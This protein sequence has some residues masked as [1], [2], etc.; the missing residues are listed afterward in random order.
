MKGSCLAGIVGTAFLLPQFIPAQQTIKVHTSLVQVDALVLHKKTG[1]TID[2]L[3]PE[4]F[5]LYEDGVLQKVTNFSKDKLP[6]SIVLALDLTQTVQPV[7]KP[8]ASGAEAALRHLKA[9]DEIAVIAYCSYAFLVDEFTTARART[10]AALKRASEASHCVIDGVGLGGPAWVNEAVYQAARYVKTESRQGTRRIVVVLNDGLRGNVPVNNRYH[11]PHTEK[12]AFAELFESGV[13]VS[14]LVLRSSLSRVGEAVQNTSPM[15][16]QLSRIYHPGSI[17]NYARRT[18]GEEIQGSRIDADVKLTAMFDRLRLFYT[19]GYISSN[20]RLD[21]KFR[22]IKLKLNPEVT[23]RTGSDIAVIAKKGY[24]A[25]A[26][27]LGD[28]PARREGSRS[29]TVPGVAEGTV[30]VPARKLACSPGGRNERWIIAQPTKE[31]G[32]RMALGPKGSPD[33]PRN[34]GSHPVAAVRS[35]AAPPPR[36]VRSRSCRCAITSS[37]FGPMDRK[38]GPTSPTI[39]PAG[40]FLNPRRPIGRDIPSALLFTSFS[41]TTST[42]MFDP[43]RDASNPAQ[44]LCALLWFV[45]S[46]SS[47]PVAG[48]S[49]ASPGFVAQSPRPSICSHSPAARGISVPVARRSAPSSLLKS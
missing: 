27:L 43:M 39:P 12:E 31:I 33:Y 45:P 4:D 13:T 25:S 29:L 24:Y 47:R 7:L 36:K 17:S 37:S 19:L 11:H 49:E 38:T 15:E 9:E 1:K 22:K 6:L 10:A 18:G 40:S 42:P 26:T 21:G 28:L 46:R 23:K 5:L 20:P 30:A 48:Y 3:R 16:I 8:L 2:S 14:G 32:I 35:I 41:K 34:L 44:D